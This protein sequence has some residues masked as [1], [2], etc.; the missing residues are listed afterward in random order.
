MKA[1]TL[2]TIALICSMPFCA[3]SQSTENRYWHIQKLAVTPDKTQEFETL[4]I[5]VAAHFE[6]VDYAY[7]YFLCR[8]TDNLYFT[9]K[10]LS[11]VSEVN[12]M[13]STTKAIWGELDKQSRK[14]YKKWVEEQETYIIMDL[15]EFS[16]IPEQ[17]RLSWND[18]LYARWEL[19]TVPKQ[20]ESAY[21]Q[22]VKDLQILKNTVWCDDPAFVFKGYDGFES[23][24]LLTL[25]YGKDQGD[26]EQQDRL[27]QDKVGSKGQ[28]LM[29]EIN[30]EVESNKIVHFWIL[31]DQSYRA[32]VHVDNL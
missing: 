23:P 25:T 22:K 16:F 9:V 21:L 18:V 10:E 32:P 12:E 28:S 7:T 11:H 27:L 30:Q 20:N 2:F 31:W 3:S 1:R 19:H 26:R 29:K 24:T 14:N 17:P 6:S 15:E 8:S 13:L 4:M 5:E